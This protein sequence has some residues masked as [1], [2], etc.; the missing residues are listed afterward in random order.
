MIAETAVC[1][2]C[3]KAGAGSAPGGGCSYCLLGL[4]LAVESPGGGV[5]RSTSS[6]SNIQAAVSPLL[7]HGVLP[8][9]GDY[10]LES[11]IA[12]G[13]MGVV[14][15]ARQKSLNR[16][17]A[18][19]LI[20]AGQLATPESVQRFRLEA[21][22]AAQLHHPGIV[23]IYEIGE[24]ETQHFFSMELVEG[25]SLAECMGEFRLIGKASAAE[26]RQQE[27]CIAELMARVARALDF[28]HQRG[29]LHRDL[30]PSNI[31]IDEQGLP[32]L[33]DFGLA[34]LMGHESNVLTVASTVL[35][36]PG[37]LSPEQAAGRA[38]VTT[39]A[40]VYGLGATLY[41]LL[42]GRPP[43]VGA[44]AVETMW[45]A[46]E[47]TP[48]QPRKLNPAVH[49]D[50][51]TIALRCLEKSP[52]R[53]YAT[54]GAVADEF[55]RFLR[56]EPIVARP[57]SRMERTWRWCQRHPALATMT[58][59]LLLAI[60][61]GSGAAGWQWHRAQRVNAQALVDAV[62]TA[63]TADVGGM[64]DDLLRY[65]QLA[66]PLLRKRLAQSGASEVARLNLTL[67]LLPFEPERST[68]LVPQLF[69]RSLEDFEIVRDA[70]AGQ[71]QKLIPSLWQTL[72][73]EGAEA[74]QRLRAACC[75]A[76]YDVQ[77][78]S[79][80]DE[81]WALHA[82]LLADTMIAVVRGDPST[83]S[84][85]VRSLRPVAEV[86]YEPLAGV[87][88]DTRR[89]ETDRSLALA[90]LIEHA[91]QRPA[92]LADLLTHADVKQFPVV[93]RTLST[94]A[95]DGRAVWRDRLRQEMPAGA[96]EHEK[97]RFASQQANAAL[98][99]LLTT[100]GTDVWPYWRHRPDSRVRSFLIDRAAPCGV[101]AELLV[102]R[103]ELE[104]DVTARRA[105]LLALGEYSEAQFS[106]ARRAEM[107]PK[108]AETYRTEPDSGLHSAAAWLL[109][110]WNGAGLVERADLELAGEMPVQRSWYVNRQGQTLAI[111]AGPVAI[112]MG[113]LPGFQ[114]DY[115]ERARR[116]VIDYSFA[117][118]C[119][120]VTVGQFDRFTGN[121]KPS[122]KQDL[123]VVEVSWFQ[124]GAYCNWLSQ[125]EGIPA[126]QWC[127]ERVPGDKVQMRLAPDFVRRTGYRLP[128]E[129]EW[130]YACRAGAITSR[131]FGNA[132]E[133]L[134][135]YAWYA[136]GGPD[137]IRR[138][139]GLLKPNDLG[140]FD[141]LGNVLEF[142]AD[143][144]VDPPVQGAR[145]GREGD[146][147][148]IRGGA[149]WHPA[150]LIR[151]TSR[152]A[153]PPSAQGFSNGFRLARTMG[154]GQGAVG[155][156]NSRQD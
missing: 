59:A 5:G 108:L 99:L 90:I 120:E 81:K 146:W 134:P 18:V 30:K 1:P 12:R 87:M 49:R 17:V 142:T 112:E 98:A 31:L 124:F 23:Q 2:R 122:T 119:Q 86:L 58:C 10:E 147:Y 22:A 54:A 84:P 3:G 6:G 55:Q 44:S 66:V 116:E 71:R 91:G 103:Y 21:E 113:D 41:E 121:E 114:D 38:E 95:G 152:I 125:Q 46:I 16:T 96:S 141:C 155:T 67:A 19:K 154:L 110:Q 129:A 35:G 92:Q 130:A 68:E 24:H 80:R 94:Q 53:R 144:Y 72:A 45:M 47:A 133:L 56:R 137:F 13:G 60:G 83:Y 151:G 88:R 111:V 64:H 9:F 52:E 20:L 153:L 117:I 50:L 140:L 135:K 127:F 93:W 136:V 74:E 28:A 11:E 123:P 32:K 48:E 51:E 57:I 104:A 73:D 101:R 139:V 149:F 100:E 33:T 65:Q 115:S 128:T 43:F 69:D 70:L 132:E 40:D 77:T 145:V 37:Y 29:V 97:D 131:S 82:K 118:G 4:G 107:M 76:S 42:T 25:L 138:P 75:L 105:L 27:Q 15:R 62:T 8:W 36:T 126:D 39:S 79:K 63:R 156:P 143:L 109:R 14:Y 85:L 102:S 148:I 78:D 7:S 150:F 26:R 61:V 89:G 106:G 34:K